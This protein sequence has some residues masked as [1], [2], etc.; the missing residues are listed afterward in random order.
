MLLMEVILED[1]MLL[2][3][4]ILE[5]FIISHGSNI[6]G[7]RSYFRGFGY[8]LGGISFIP[9]LD[10]HYACLNAL[11]FGKNLLLFTSDNQDRHAQ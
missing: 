6:R 3:E 11:H 7:K 2:M 8:C 10:L 1:R 4:V 9:V 5:Y